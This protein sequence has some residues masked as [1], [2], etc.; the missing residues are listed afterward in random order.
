MST[1]PKPEFKTSVA[2]LAA[3]GATVAIKTTASQQELVKQYENALAQ[4]TCLKIITGDIDNDV[5]FVNPA[6]VIMV[7][8]R[9]FV[10]ENTRATKAGIL[11]PNRRVQ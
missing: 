4:G 6:H 8:I 5:V 10:D 7:S 3:S 11:L 2:L 1:P 9:D